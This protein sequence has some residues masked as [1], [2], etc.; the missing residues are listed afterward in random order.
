VGK[1][2]F[3]KVIARSPA[4]V[5]Q[6]F[7]QKPGKPR[8]MPWADAVNGHSLNTG[9]SRMGKSKLLEKQAISLIAGKGLASVI[10]IDSHAS[11]STAILH[12]CIRLGV[13][14]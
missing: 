10:V 4:A 3:Q 1:K 8:P 6:R 11:T 7:E 14:P 9:I 2:L 13:P 5:G 12:A